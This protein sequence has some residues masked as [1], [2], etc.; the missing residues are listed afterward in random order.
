M[1]SAGT[2]S[3]CFCN[4]KKYTANLLNPISTPL[5]IS[6]PLWYMAESISNQVARV[7]LCHRLFWDKSIFVLLQ[8]LFDPYIFIFVAKKF[9]AFSNAAKFR[10]NPYLEINFFNVIFKQLLLLQFFKLFSM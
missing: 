10:D 6:M 8:K 7:C 1:C 4:R 3:W 2:D 9:H 5:S